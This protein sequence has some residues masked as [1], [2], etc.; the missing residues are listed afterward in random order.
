[1]LG[2]L[3]CGIGI[4]QQSIQQARDIIIKKVLN[5]YILKVGCQTVVFE[6][7]NQMLSEI[8]RYYDNPSLVEKEYME[9][10]SIQ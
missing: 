9:K 10:F 3:G 1:M 6:Q 7:K 2:T 4:G 5:G 8:G